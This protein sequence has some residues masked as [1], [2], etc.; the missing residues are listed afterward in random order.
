M[1][2]VPR[3]SRKHSAL[4]NASPITSPMSSLKYG[5]LQPPCSKPPSRSSSGPPG[6]CIT[7]SR[8]MNVAIVTVPMHALLPGRQRV[9]SSDCP[10][11]RISS[12]TAVA[13]LGSRGGGED[14]GR[15]GDELA[16]GG[17]RGLLIQP[18][19]D[20]RVERRVGGER[21]VDDAPPDG[22]VQGEREWGSGDVA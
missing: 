18:V 8:D 16:A 22:L 15:R 12:V 6:A 9:I 14:A 20:G 11:R 2:Y 17:G 3:P 13:P 10:G 5:K 1:S 4:P 21:A 19:R 7:P